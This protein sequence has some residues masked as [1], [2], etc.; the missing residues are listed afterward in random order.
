MKNYLAKFLSVQPSEKLG[1]PYGGNPQNPQ[2]VV[3][4]IGAPMAKQP[5]KPSKPTF[6]GFEGTPPKPTP[7]FQRPADEGGELPAHIRDG[8]AR[9]GIQATTDEYGPRL[10]MKMSGALYIAVA[11]YRRERYLSGAGKTKAVDQ[12]LGTFMSLAPEAE[13]LADEAWIAFD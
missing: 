7:E 10:T 8:L 12:E 11:N 4:N 5:S 13:E 9:E 1:N 6:E 2:K 3:R